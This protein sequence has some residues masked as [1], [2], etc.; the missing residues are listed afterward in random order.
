MESKSLKH[1]FKH[2]T[3]ERNKRIYLPNGDYMG[4]ELTQSVQIESKNVEK[5]VMISQATEGAKL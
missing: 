1:N 4:Y 2:K 3:S 5:I